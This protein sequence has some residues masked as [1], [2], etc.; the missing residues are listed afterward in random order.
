I[1][2]GRLPLE[3]PAVATPD[4]DTLLPGEAA[5]EAGHPLLSA[6]G[7][8]ARDT[9]R[10][11][12]SDEF[13]GMIEP[14]LGDLMEYD[15]PPRDTLLHRV[16]ADIVELDCRGSPQGMADTDTSFEV[17]ACHSPLR[18]IQ[19]LQDQLLDR[20]AAEDKRVAAGE[21]EANDRLAPRDVIV[22]LPDVAAYAPAIQAVFGGAPADRYLP[23]GLADRARSAAHPIVTCVSALLDLPL[24][25]WAASELLDLLAVPAVMRR[26]GLSAGELDTITDWVI[27][28]GIRWGRNK[29]HRAELG[30]GAFEQN[31]W[32]FGLDRLL[33]GVAQSDDETLTDG[34][35]PWA[36]LEGGI[37]AALG[38]LWRFEDTL[39]IVAEDLAKP[40]TPGEW[41]TRL[42]KMVDDLIEPAM[43]T[44]DEQRAVD[45]L[46]SVFARFD[47]A[48][49]CTR[50]KPL[51]ADRTISW[52]A[53]RDAL[54]ATLETAAERQP[55]LAGGITFCGMVP[56]RAVPFR[57]VCVL[58]MNDSA[59]P[60]QDTGR[61]FNVM[62]DAPRLGD[63]N[64]RDDDRL[65]FLQA[66]TAARDAFYISYIGQ[67][68]NTG[69][70]LPPSP[71]VGETL[72]FL[73]RH[74][75]D[76]HDKKA[77]EARLIHHQPMQP[78]S[79]R[80]FSPDEPDNRVF[81]YAGDWR[82]ATRAAIGAREA[83]LPMLD[84]S[85]APVAET[86]AAIDLDTLKRFFDHPARAFFRE[87]IKLN[88][89][90]EDH[91]VD[92]A[93]PIALGPLAAAQLRERLFASADKAEAT[94]ID[95]APTALERARGTLP[96]PPL[97]DPNYAAEAEA[98][99]EL[100]PIWQAW[101]A[102]GAPET[103]DIQIEDVAGVRITGR[104]AQCWPN[105]MRRLRTGKLKTRFRLRYWIDYLAVVAV[106]HD[107]ALEMAGFAPDQK[108]AE[109]IEYAGR[110]DADTARAELAHLVQRYIDGQTRP[111]PYHPDLDDS[112]NPEQNK[113]FDNLSFRFKPTAYFPHHLTRDAY[114]SMLLGPPEAPLGDT[115]DDSPFIAAIDAISGPMNARIGPIT[116]D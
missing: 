18:E 58:G 7:R 30:A 54:R 28:A 70:A 92:D 15:V 110:L 67:D 73:R 101:K 74:Y 115:G 32:R 66:L 19:V 102:E 77:F 50:D 83:R 75:F 82:D 76:G 5:V 3:L 36:D 52:P 72:E 55:F 41:Q 91:Q 94:A 16:Q 57:M 24:S 8:M 79:L 62:F 2:A 95:L 11:L 29:Q 61:A 43:D 22:M 108:T 51:A 13:A 63:R 81:T 27:D 48:E 12:Y 47:T 69:E 106:G 33:L 98:V 99:N 88:L 14:E 68:V 96:P 78:F 105:A 49:T 20:L 17:H 56:L 85:T 100:L 109:R 42:N 114:F 31:S 107:L 60:H 39:A 113:A 80:Y 116:G 10:V 103:L 21:I 84:D 45:S 93:E 71:I 40:A 25:R 65:L 23:F 53:V 37:T 86:V 34:V 87:R 6:L 112:Y 26:F 46:R 4:D 90:I 1:T 64:T 111:L 9:L 38:K 59:F 104:V 35:A 97:A 44:P 89:E